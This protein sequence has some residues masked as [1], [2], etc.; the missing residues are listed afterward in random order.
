MRSSL[1]RGISGRW[2]RSDWVNSTRG[3][4][5]VGRRARAAAG[6]AA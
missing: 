4:A 2:L 3:T 5:R 6:A 1:R